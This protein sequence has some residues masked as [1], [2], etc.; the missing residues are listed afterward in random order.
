MTVGYN[1][2]IH[3]LVTRGSSYQANHREPIGERASS[4][5]AQVDMHLRYAA[6]KPKARSPMG[7]L[8][9]ATRTPHDSKGLY[10]LRG[11]KHRHRVPGGCADQPVREGLSKDTGEVVKSSCIRVNRGVMRA[12][13][14][15]ALSVN[16]SINRWL[17]AETLGFTLA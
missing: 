8:L 2:Q 5:L 1:L 11:S 12:V 4:K 6:T 9:S 16:K 17:R 3:G 15:L 10:G 13:A 14:F 7:F